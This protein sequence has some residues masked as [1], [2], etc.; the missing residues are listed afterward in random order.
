MTPQRTAAFDRILEL[1][2]TADE[3]E[4][5]LEITECTFYRNRQSLDDDDGF[6]PGFSGGSSASNPE[7]ELG[8]TIP[9]PTVVRLKST[10]E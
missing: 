9:P 5:E 4:D 3:S 2:V 7:I 8:Q 6:T 1:E 10:F